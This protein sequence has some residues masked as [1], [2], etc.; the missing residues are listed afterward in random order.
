MLKLR[1]KHKKPQIAKAILGRKINDGGVP[2]PNFR[3]YDRAIITKIA[4][5]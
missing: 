1:W 3:L 5:F 2:K 4:Q